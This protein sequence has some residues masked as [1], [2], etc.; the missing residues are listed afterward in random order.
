MNPIQ[1]LIVDDSAVSRELLTHIIESDS[2]LKVVGKV[3]NGEEALKFISENKPHIVM[4][5]I[6][7]PKM[8]GYE[9]TRRIMESFPLPIIIVSGIYNAKEVKQG[10]RALS[11]GALAILSKPAGLRDPKYQEIAQSL[12]QA[13]KVLSNVKIKPRPLSVFHSPTQT[14]PAPIFAKGTLSVDAIAIGASVGATQSLSTILS[15]LPQDF[16]V[17][18]LITQQFGS[19]FMEGLVDWLA[20]S[21][22]LKTKL[23]TDG[24]VLAPSTIY[25]CPDKHHLEVGPGKTLKLTPAASNQPA[26]S[27]DLFFRSIADQMGAKSIAILLAGHGN[28]GID[29]LLA[30]KQK[31]GLALVQDEE[32]SLLAEKSHQAIEAG[33]ASQVVSLNEIAT[34]LESL[35]KLK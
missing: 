23:A 22:A 12:I 34:T 25:V 15:P 30:I 31:G 8:D 29:G 16:P 35:V 3:E 18:I 28:D 17:P 4:M 19:G 32:S 7:M 5:D 14:Q 6:V 10:Y 20:S 33:A 2:G 9:A 21:C 13:I 27:I 11:A 1:V 24:E 26:P